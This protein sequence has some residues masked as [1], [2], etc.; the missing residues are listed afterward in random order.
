MTS[1][2]KTEQPISVIIPTYNGVGLLEKHLPALEKNLRKNDTLII[3]D[4]ASS[5]D[6]VTWLT[7]RYALSDKKQSDLSTT[8]FP[9]GYGISHSLGRDLFQF[10]AYTSIN[11]IVIG[12]SKNVR[13]AEAVNTAVLAVPTEWFLLLNNDV[14]VTKSTIPELLKCTG[15]NV[16][17]IAPLEY[18]DSVT[19]EKS[20]R[21][22]LW[23]EKGLYHHSKADSFD[24]GPTA[25]VSGGSGLFHTQ[26]WKD[27]GGFDLQYYPAYWEDVDIS[28]SA[29]QR[30]W[31]VLF[32]ADSVVLHQHETTNK[33]T[34]G[35][36][37]V[38][39]MSAAHARYFTWKHSTFLQKILFLLWQP[40]WR[41]KL[42]TI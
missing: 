42:R 19:G 26:K 13:F 40:Y 41:W 6:T 17:G 1:F 28:F 27:L 7:Q 4:D 35:E 20:G 14:E 25:W 24:S 22:K 36:D 16:F 3:V 31:N 32:C 5:D 37:N 38:A 23:F 34:F 9:H 8:T 39:R 18:Q 30:G 2:S 29:K 33:Q 21:N 10:G 11:V 12:L 15:P